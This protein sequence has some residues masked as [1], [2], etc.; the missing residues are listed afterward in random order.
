MLFRITLF[1]CLL[2]LSSCEE[3]NE[4]PVLTAEQIAFVEA[5]A[6]DSIKSQFTPLSP[7]QTNY[8]TG[9]QG[10]FI[11]VPKRA[12]VLPDGSSPKGEIRLELKEANRLQDLVKGRIST[13]AGDRLLST[14][15]TVYIGATADGQELKMRKGIQLT[16]AF[17]SVNKNPDMRLFTGQ[18]TASDINWS[19]ADEPEETKLR[20]PVP[21]KLEKPEGYELLGELRDIRLIKRILHQ[22][23]TGELQPKGAKYVP[24]DQGFGKMS[25]SKEYVE[26]CRNWLAWNERKEAAL[27]SLEAEYKRENEALQEAW[28]TYREANRTFFEKTQPEKAFYRFRVSDTGWMNC[29]A[30]RSEELVAIKGKI[31][32]EHQSAYARVHLISEQERIHLNV[33][34]DKQGQFTFYFPPETPFEIHAF[35]GTHK[36]LFIS[37]GY[38]GEGPLALEMK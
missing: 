36:G 30:F 1:T 38:M 10:T 15:G 29:D 4:V 17:P 5:P 22:I 27:L 8:I 21:P 13:L 34:T 11:K 23:G 18:P 7:N 6:T 26:A 25:W 9:K 20:P 35:N 31:T 32:D 2:I 28:Q 19:L 12:F 24:S 3:K 16:V 33:N 14:A 37:D